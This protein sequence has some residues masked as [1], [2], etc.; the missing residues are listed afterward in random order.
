MLTKSASSYHSFEPL[1]PQKVRVALKYLQRVNPLYHNVF[2]RDGN[3]YDNLL[4]IGSD[5]P[6]RD[7]D[8]DVRSDHELESVANRLMAHR[9]AAN[10]SLVVENENL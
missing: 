2:I 4:S 9:H 1:R 10:E 7:I 5:F 3:T 8:F 6:G